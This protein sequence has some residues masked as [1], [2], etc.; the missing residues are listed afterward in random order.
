MGPEHSKMR[1][2]LSMRLPAATAAL[3]AVASPAPAAT[4]AERPVQARGDAS[5]F[6]TVAKASARGSWRA[7]VRANPALGAA[8]ANW[9]IA[10]GAGYDCTENGGAYTCT[11]IARP[12]RD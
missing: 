11:A 8:Y 9:S 1:T 6:E 2:G 3:L 5:R 12:C 4:C 7:S 10:Q